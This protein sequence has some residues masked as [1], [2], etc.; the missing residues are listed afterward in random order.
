MLQACEKPFRARS[1]RKAPLPGRFQ[2]HRLPAAPIR[3]DDRHMRE[4]FAILA[5]FFE[6]D[7]R[8]MHMRTFSGMKSAEI[9]S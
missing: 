2:T 7:A 8:E 4:L 5:D 3:I 1:L 9:S 6:T